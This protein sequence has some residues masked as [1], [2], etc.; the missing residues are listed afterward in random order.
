MSQARDAAALGA[1]VRDGV[2]ST[3]WAGQPLR[4]VHQTGSTNDDVREAGRAGAEHGYTLVADAQTAGRG[5]R[6]RVWHSPVGANLYVSILTRPRLAVEDSP[7]LALIVGLAVARAVDRFVGADV[8]VKWPNDVRIGRR[9]CAGILVEGAIRDG[10][11]DTAVVGIGLNVLA[12]EWPEE[13]RA[14]ATSIEAHTTVDVSRAAVLVA[15][16][17]ECER[18][19]DAMLL[20]GSSR[21]RLVSELASRCDTI[22]SRVDI[23]GVSGIATRIESD[24][25]LVVKGDD[26][27]EHLVRSGEVR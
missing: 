4:F 19:I 22:G 24:G 23:D 5:R 12:R 20:G 13:L 8:S 21:S 14:T 25:A 6:G 11:L 3:K 15:V 16:L 27:V 17:E 18:A 2:S 9:K 26:G 1:L 7:M 10:L